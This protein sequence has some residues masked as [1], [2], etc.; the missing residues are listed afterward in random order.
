LLDPPKP[1]T[2]VLL[3]QFLESRDVSPVRYSLVTPWED[4]APRTKRHHTRKA[5][6]VVDACLQEI[7]PEDHQQLF[8]SVCQ[9]RA[10]SQEFDSVLIDALAECY[11]NASHWSTRRQ[12][13]SIISDKV[14][15][16]DLLKWVPDLTRYRYTLARHHRLLHGR[17]AVTP[18]QPSS[19]MYIETEKLEHFL[20]FITSSHVIQEIPFGER[21]LKLSSNTEIKVPNVIRTMIPE[22]IIRQ[23]GSYCSESGFVPPS[24]STLLRILKVCSASVR[25]SLQGLDNFSAEGANGFDELEEIA[26]KIGD[27]YNKGLS[28]SKTQKEKLKNA[29]RY[30]KSD[31]KVYI[32]VSAL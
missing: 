23:Y 3:N 16:K 13:L 2:K 22:Q 29:K 19:R 17:G 25:K 15:F 7:A 26:E 21:S 20:T 10:S 11:Q 31:Y 4:A 5:K 1:A 14:K 27:D 24:R 6:Q 32:M 30:L 8:D 18:V 12:I 9:A 28:W